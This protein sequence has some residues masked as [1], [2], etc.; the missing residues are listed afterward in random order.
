MP[1]TRMHSPSFWFPF[2]L[3]S[4]T[5]ALASVMA[6]TLF[7]NPANDPQVIELMSY[8]WIMGVVAL[9]FILFTMVYS[10]SVDR[11][12]IMNREYNPIGMYVAFL[13]GLGALAIL[14]VFAP[15]T[16]T[17]SNVGFDLSILPMDENVFMFI[18]ATI[19]ELFFRIALGMFIYMIIPSNESVKLLSALIGTAGGFAVWHW[20]AYQAD[21]GMMMIALFA[22]VLLFIGFQ[23]GAKVGGG[24]LSFIGIVAG[25][26]LWN[27]S[28]VGA[29]DS[30]LLVGVFL[31]I[32]TV[33]VLFV[34]PRTSRVMINYIK[35]VIR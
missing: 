29:L 11:T 21:L 31:V 3:F 33:I 23:L 27:I 35:G 7:L 34:S 20:F 16:N 12:Q 17:F 13:F 18:V 15:T 22:G 14:K 10:G 6:M 2:G 4:L 24:E 5:F 25:H 9:F 30:F 26:W 8:F 1:D 28:S 19:E 32:M